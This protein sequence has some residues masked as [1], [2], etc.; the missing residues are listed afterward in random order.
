MLRPV[1]SRSP[2]GAST[3]PTP[4]TAPIEPVVEFAP[5]TLTVKHWGRLLD[6]ELL[7]TSPYI[8]WAKLMRRTLGLD[9]LACPKCAGRLRVLSVIDHP[10][11]AKRI[12]DPL[13]LRSE[14]PPLAPARAPPMDQM[15]FGF[16]S[17]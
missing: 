11:V 16:E 14:P 9:V 15:G 12:P 4:P 13:G 3:A 17:A 8:D 5:T 6:G 7:A 2:L 10:T 1:T